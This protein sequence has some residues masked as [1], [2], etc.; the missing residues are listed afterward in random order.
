M[1]NQ[2]ESRNGI[3]RKDPNRPS[4]DV[5]G[6]A[7]GQAS[8]QGTGDAPERHEPGEHRPRADEKG[9]AGVA[10]DGQAD[11]PAPSD[12]NGSSDPDAK[13]AR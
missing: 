10:S 8:G 5:G 9:K 6:P 12:R 4:P 1:P 7:D 13:R 3:P 11:L 2:E